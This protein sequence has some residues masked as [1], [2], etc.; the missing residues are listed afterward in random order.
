[1][2]SHTLR[3]GVPLVACA[4]C[5]AAH[6]T[7]QW[8]DS[9][10]AGPN[11]LTQFD[12]NG[13]NTMIGPLTG[14]QIPVTTVDNGAEAYTPDKAGEPLGTTIT[15]TS[16]FS[17]LYNFTWSNLNPNDSSDIAYEAAGFL[18]S[19]TPQTRQIMGVIL[20][21]WY[22]TAS[23]ASSADPQGYYV[24]LDLLFGSVGIVDTGYQAGPS[25][26]VGNT[27]PTATMQLAIGFDPTSNTLSAGLY[28]ATGDLLGSHSATLTMTGGMYGAHPAAYDTNAN[29]QAELNNLSA[30]YLGWEDYTG[31]GNNI[32]TTW[33]M[34]SLSFYNDATGA[35]SAATGL[36]P[37]PAG[38]AMLAG[39]S[40]LGFLGA[41]HR[42][43]VV[44]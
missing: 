28:D 18:G 27:N 5:S 4:L 42:R 8:D 9:F 30:S 38:M 19:A 33:D 7:L 39:I 34:N 41:R 22:V 13:G 43:R 23:E 6:A 20:R 25:I 24:G 31:N 35:F 12:T 44:R 26:Y 37:E 17:G 16:A 36:A 3:F 1:M 2:R 40:A 21:H 29:I 11:G 10:S 15:G 32:P 14:G